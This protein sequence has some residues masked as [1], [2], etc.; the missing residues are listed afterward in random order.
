M[1]PEASTAMSASASTSTSPRRGEWIAV[2]WMVNAW[3]GRV[4][5]RLPLPAVCSREEAHHQD[6]VEISPAMLQSPELGAVGGKA[7]AHIEPTRGIVARHDAEQYLLDLAAG[8][9]D[10]GCHERAPQ[11]AAP[12]RLPHVEPPEHS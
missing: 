7:V 6:L 10:H 4:M 2:P 11:A 1:A 9:I 8:V 3:P 5:P 12:D